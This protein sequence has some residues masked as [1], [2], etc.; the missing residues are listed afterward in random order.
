MRAG[1]AF[2]PLPQV[3]HVESADSNGKYLS[4][5]LITLLP[6][7]RQRVVSSAIKRTIN[8]VLDYASL[9]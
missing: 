3:W 7:L 8:I 6:A 1:D 9:G 5:L 2:S 4:S